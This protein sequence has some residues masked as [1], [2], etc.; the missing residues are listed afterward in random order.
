MNLFSQN[1]GQEYPNT[2]AQFAD[3]ENNKIPCKSKINKS[4]IL[5]GVLWFYLAT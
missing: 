2:S 5:G 1:I 4:V 3:H